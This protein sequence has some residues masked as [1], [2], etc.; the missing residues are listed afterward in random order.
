MYHRQRKNKQRIRT[1]FS[2]FMMLFVFIIVFICHIG[3]LNPD[4]TAS[5]KTSFQDTLKGLF[6]NS[7]KQD[8][9]LF[10]SE[11]RPE[12]TTLSVT[13]LDVGQGNCVLAESDGHY[14]LIDGGDRSHSSFVVSYLQQAGI[15]ALDYVLISHYD[16]DHVSGVIGALYQFD[17]GNVLSPDYSADTKI[18]QSYVNCLKK[19]NITPVHP[20]VGDTYILGNASFTVVCPDRYDYEEENNRSLGI[21]LTDSSHSFLILG[22]AQSKS[23]SAMLNENLDLS[24]DV[25]M[26]SHHG[27]ASSSTEKFLHAVHPAFAVISVGADNDYGHPAQKNTFPLGSTGYSNPAYRFKRNNHSLQHPRHPHLEYRTVRVRSDKTQTLKHPPPTNSLT[28]ELIGMFSLV[29]G[30]KYARNFNR[31]FAS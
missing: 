3:L 4:L 7:S 13:F 8:T 11:S 21:R 17:V 25:Y 10:Y 29:Y 28:I 26:V 16:A 1:K 18:Y 5:V 15:T 27:S 6:T 12:N 20:Q 24:A 22:D 2:A 30:R 23:E 19:Q 14:M 9:A 31:R